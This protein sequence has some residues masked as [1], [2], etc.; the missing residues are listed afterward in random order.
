MVAL[1]HRARTRAAWILLPV[2]RR[3]FVA[4]AGAGAFADGERLRVPRDDEGETA[5]RRG[6]IS[7]SFMPEELRRQVERQCKGRFVEEAS[8][9]CSAVDYTSVA[10]GRTDFRVYYRLLPWDHAPPALIVCEAGGVSVH[11]DGRAYA[12]L[13]P[14]EPTIVARSA[15]VAADVCDWMRGGSPSTSGEPG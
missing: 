11:P 13:D 10:E 15:R 8:G 6:Y 1:V 14:N 2:R 4:E 5:P 9:G 12:P 7:T 3:L